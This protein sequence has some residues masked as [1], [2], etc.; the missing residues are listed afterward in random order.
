MVLANLLIEA[1]RS[2]LAGEAPKGA[3]LVF[4]V[5]FPTDAVALLAALDS[6]I[7]DA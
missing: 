5:F 2:G 1:P 3:A 6:V 4:P 7:L